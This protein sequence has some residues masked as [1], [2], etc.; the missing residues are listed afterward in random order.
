MQNI[1]WQF[2]Y[3]LNCLFTQVLHHFCCVRF[4]QR[5]NKLATHYTC[6]VHC[7]CMH[8]EVH[9]HCKCVTRTLGASLFYTPTLSFC[10]TLCCQHL[11]FGA[12]SLF[13]EKMFNDVD[14]EVLSQYI[15]IHIKNSYQMPSTIE[16]GGPINNCPLTNKDRWI[17]CMI[18]LNSSS[19]PIWN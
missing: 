7:C 4:I 2:L 8:I 5:S 12:T 19:W 10:C 16:L 3:I 9:H 18:G 14:N 11:F 15:G 6:F 17:P 13:L 1:T